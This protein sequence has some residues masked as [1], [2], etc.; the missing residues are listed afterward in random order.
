[1]FAYCN[2]NPVVYTD[3]SGNLTYYSVKNASTVKESEDN[4]GTAT[5]SVKIEYTATISNPFSLVQS[6][7]EVEGDVIFTFTV[8]SRGVVVFNNNDYDHGMVGDDNIS[9][10]LANEIYYAATSHVDGALSGRTVKGIA[11]E[12]RAHFKVSTTLPV[13]KVSIADIGGM[14]KSRSDYDY[15]AKM[16]ED[17]WKT[18]LVIW[19]MIGNEF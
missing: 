15:N 9:A 14:D 7:V 6:D 8:D 4:Y 11:R 1:M 3:A 12:L 17:P 18:P 19:E 13:N 16:F 5:Y 2:N 10:A